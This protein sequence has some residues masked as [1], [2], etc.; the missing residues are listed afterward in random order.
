[1]KVVSNYVLAL[2]NMQQ[3]KQQTANPPKQT[4][5]KRTATKWM[6]TSRI[7]TESIAAESILCPNL[8]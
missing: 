7:T 1:M 6:G 5:T 8:C 3:E 2:R 4:N